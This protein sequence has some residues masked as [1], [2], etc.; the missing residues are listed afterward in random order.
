MIKILVFGDSIAYGAWD[1]EGGWVQRLESFLYNKNPLKS[2][3]HNS[4]RV[5]YN[6]GISGNSTEEVLKRF[7]NQT[8]KILEKKDKSIIIFAIGINDSQFCKNTN[9]FKTS[10][11]IFKIN[12]KK[13]I[14]LAMKF[15]SK[16]IFLGLTPVDETETVS[17][18]MNECYK[19]EYI[20][21][22]NETIKYICKENNIYFIEVF[23]KLIKNYKELLKDGLHPNSEGHK[24][25]FEI[26]KYFLI[27]NKII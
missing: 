3:N 24:K 12:I 4:H 26:V 21:N 9:E 1:K 8:K 19:N 23:N 6:L 25:I 20:K 5:V 15:H 18:K 27:K 17:W 16:V 13:L 14:N 10:P 22:Y 7:E 11:K 2:S